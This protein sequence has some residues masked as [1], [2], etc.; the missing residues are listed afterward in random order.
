MSNDADKALTPKQRAFVERY[1]V[2]RNGAQAAREA[3]YSEASAN[4]SAHVLLDKPNVRAAVAAAEAALS[5]RNLVDQDYVVERLKLEAEGADT[6]SARVSALGLL[7]K[8]LGMFV[9]R[10]ASADGGPLQVVINT[11]PKE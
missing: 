5:K 7:G 6:A 9:E 10:L 2:H 3:G 1:L 8:H 11:L 4:V